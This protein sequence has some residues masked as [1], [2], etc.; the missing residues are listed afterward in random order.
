M[1]RLT[2]QWVENAREKCKQALG[3]RD[4]K[5]DTMKRFPVWIQTNLRNCIKPRRW[6]TV[7]LDAKKCDAEGCGNKNFQFKTT[8]LLFEVVHYVEG[9]C[10]R[11]ICL[12]CWEEKD[13]A[14]GS[15]TSPST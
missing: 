9:G 8:Q 5:L 2:Q 11:A 14:L 13:K 10:T 7:L 3:R 4:E 12:D 6:N 1:E 15:E